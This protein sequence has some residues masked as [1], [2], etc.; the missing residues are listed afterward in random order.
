MSK[1]AESILSLIGNTPMVKLKRIS[2]GIPAEIWAKLEF[3]NPSG[4]VKDRIALKMLQ[5]AERRG[6]I[7]QGT[8]IVEPTSGNTGISLAL[9]CALKGYRM[10][11]VM[12]EARVKRERDSWS[13]WVQRSK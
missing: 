4:S 11:A 7:K 3:F 5:E 12:P 9:V 2:K 8:V 13:F 6:Q 1:P 10:I